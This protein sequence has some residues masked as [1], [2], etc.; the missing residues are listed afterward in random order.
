M[1]LRLGDDCESAELLLPH[2]ASVRHDTAS[3]AAKTL[4]IRRIERFPVNAR[5][6]RVIVFRGYVSCAQMSVE[7]HMSASGD[8]AMLN[9]AIMS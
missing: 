3:A 2:A 1:A 4:I 9:I 8:L 5:A 7:F 6:Y